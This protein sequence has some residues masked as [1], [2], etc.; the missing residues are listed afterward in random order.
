VSGETIKRPPAIR[1]SNVGKRYVKY[2]DTPALLTSILRMGT[3]TRRSQL[4]AV[5]GLELEV[6]QGET[7]GIIGRNGSGKT[8]TLRMLAGVTAPTEGELSVRGRI[9]PLISVG[10]GFHDE[11]TGRENVYVNGAVLGMSRAEIDGLFD[12]IVAFAELEDFIDTPVKFYSSGMWL[13]LG[14]SVAIASRP[15]IL[16]VDEVLAVGDL[17][18][19]MKCY[20]RMVEMKEQ[21]TSVV[22]VSHSL[23]AIRNLCSRVLVLHRGETQFLGKTHEAIS[24]YHRLLEGADDAEAAHF[25]PVEGVECE[26]LGPDGSKTQHLNYGE[27]ATCRVRARFK[28]VVDEPSFVFV[29][30]TESGLPIYMDSNHETIRARVDAGR[31]V[32]CDV[33]FRST[34]P[35]GT[36]SLRGG[37]RWG[38][39]ADAI[40][41]SGLITFFVSGRHL[42]FGVADLEATFDVG[43]TPTMPADTAIRPDGIGTT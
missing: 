37:V 29:L 32:T 8:T 39:D 33:R 27:V 31:E 2:E 21:G 18:F 13:R 30:T 19:Q 24:V 10:V 16:L 6:E 9:A 4:W 1:M 7:I 38:G 25:G 3:R 40:A 35:T 41:H 22:V 34:L 14:F 43:E 12:S 11:L 23:E 5:R 28:T 36:Y 26:L 17:G 20:E 15:E 42:V